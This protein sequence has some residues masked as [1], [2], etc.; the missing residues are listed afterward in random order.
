MTTA[1]YLTDTKGWA[2]V[3][4]NQVDAQNKTNVMTQ[5]GKMAL[6]ELAK[7]V[8]NAAMLAIVALGALIVGFL[9]FKLT[10]LLIAVIAFPTAI[11][12]PLYTLLMTVGGVAAG[13]V[14]SYLFTKKYGQ[15]FFNQ[16][17]EHFNY[18]MHLFGECNKVRTFQTVG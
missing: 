15:T 4:M 18:S 11:I 12:P 14:V 6:I 13:G 10:S 1:I 17:K 5:T 8:G 7:S 3:D 9:A 16:M 2:S